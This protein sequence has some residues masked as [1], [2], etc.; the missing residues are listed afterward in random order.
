MQISPLVGDDVKARP[1]RL[2]KG[3]SSE[4]W[5]CEQVIAILFDRARRETGAAADL[6]IVKA[7]LDKLRPIVLDG[8]APDVAAL[9][10]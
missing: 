7:R 8:L 9:F 4:A 6:A 5:A 2:H 10:K 1:R 3:R